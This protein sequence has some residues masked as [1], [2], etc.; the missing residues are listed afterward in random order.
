MSVDEFIQVS[1]RELLKNFSMKESDIVV[2]LAGNFSKGTG[3]SFIEVGTVG[4]LMERAGVT[5][6]ELMA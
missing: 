4:Y 5:R 2:A 3:F 1:V 6:Q